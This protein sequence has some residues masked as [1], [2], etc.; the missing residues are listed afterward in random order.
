[1]PRSRPV[2]PHAQTPIP[3]KTTMTPKRASGGSQRSSRMKRGNASS[4]PAVPGASGASPVPNPSAMKWAGWAKTKRE[5]G[6]DELRAP[7]GRFQDMAEIGEQA[8]GDVDRA[9]RKA[10]QPHA[11]IDARLGRVQAGEAGFERRAFELH[12]P[13]QVGE[14]ERR[15]PGRAREPDIV[16]GAR[17]VALER[18]LRRHLAHHGD[19][20]RKGPSGRVPADEP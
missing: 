12:A 2:R 5:A 11:E 9:A 16:P 3:K 15:L 18:E 1:M 10:A 13:L 4:V 8:V 6:P 14:R 7:A 20:D 19:R 17:R